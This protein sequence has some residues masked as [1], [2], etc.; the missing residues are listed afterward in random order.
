MAFQYLDWLSASDLKNTADL[1]AGEGDVLSSGL[2]KIAVY[3]DYDNSLK[4]FSAVCPHLGCIVQW[5]RDEKSFDC[6]CHGSR[7]ATD[8][9]VINGPSKTDLHKIN[10]KN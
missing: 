2:K 7:F 5:N 4:A 9:T 8:G 6:P 10:I 1:P 3:R